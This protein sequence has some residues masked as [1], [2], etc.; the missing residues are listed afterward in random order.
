MTVLALIKNIFKQTLI[1]IL[2]LIFL[3]SIPLLIGLCVPIY[4]IR[5]IVEIAAKLFRPDL[6]KILT[7]RS[8][9]FAVDDLYNQPRAPLL[10]FMILEG[11]IDVP[12]AQLNLYKKL[13]EAKNPDGTFVRPELTQ[14]ISK[15]MGFYF[16]KKDESFDITNHAHV[17][18]GP[19]K[20]AYYT[21]ERLYEIV[22]NL[23]TKPFP[24]HRSPWE[25]I[26][27]EK[28]VDEAKGQQATGVCLLL[29]HSLADGFSILKL[30]GEL[31]TSKG[32][33]LPLQNYTPST[34]FRRFMEVIA[35][36][37]MAPYETVKVL[38]DLYDS[39]EWHI[40]EKK[41]SRKMNGAVLDKIPVD[42]IKEI[43]N[44]SGCSF[45]SVLLAA[46]SGGIR[47]FMLEQGVKVPKTIHCISPLPM[48]G[49]PDKMR[50]F[51]LVN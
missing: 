16:W 42:Y 4:T 11:D 35:M 9:V 5:Y 20:S 10:V 26:L 18:D 19:M 37:F 33:I 38:F 27:F 32:R 45:T 40:P 49:H 51:M 1:V 50:N 43:K 41:L 23:V 21:E 46:F 12:E 2:T 15:W 44:L 3:P 14:Y 25:F 34:G 29:H 6:C 8:A 7:T 47:N 24:K 30:V 28:C 36:S 39:N 13:V 48:V 17:Y 31:I 22:N